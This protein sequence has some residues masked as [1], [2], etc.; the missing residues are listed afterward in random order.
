MTGMNCPKCGYDIFEKY[1]NVLSGGKSKFVKI[2]NI[3][4][5]KSY[6]IISGYGWDVECTCP[7]CKT[8]WMFDDSDH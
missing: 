8:E 6:D 7:K 4:P 2:T 1:Q 3:Y 5:E